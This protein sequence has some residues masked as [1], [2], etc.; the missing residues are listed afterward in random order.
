MTIPEEEFVILQEKI[1]NWGPFDEGLPKLRNEI[2]G[3][4]KKYS[5]D[6]PS[7]IREF[8][9]WKSKQKY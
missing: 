5:T 3:I 4:A 9:D 7:V 6:S 1:K 8:F 2:S